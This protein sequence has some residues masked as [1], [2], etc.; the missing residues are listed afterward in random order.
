MHEVRKDIVNQVITTV[1]TAHKQNNKEI[2]SVRQMLSTQV[3]FSRAI[4]P[5]C[6]ANAEHSI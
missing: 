4:I 2:C 1:W 3:E 6:D 5:I